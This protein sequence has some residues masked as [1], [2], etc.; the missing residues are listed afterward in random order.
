M[1]ILNYL[2]LLIGAY[3]VLESI[4]VLNQTYFTHNLF[5]SI[6]HI[7]AGSAGLWLVFDGW[8]QNDNALNILQGVVLALFMWE[9]ME[10]RLG[11]R[12]RLRQLR[13]F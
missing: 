11:I 5:C 10:L 6:K 3:L 8:A 4:I 12:A 13:D 2:M 9:R 1:A 7:L